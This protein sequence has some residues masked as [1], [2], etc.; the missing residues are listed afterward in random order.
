MLFK[1]WGAA[2]SIPGIWL[3]SAKAWCS[4]V[5][6]KQTAG[7]ELGKKPGR[8]LPGESL[9]S[10]RGCEGKEVQEVRPSSSAWPTWDLLHCWPPYTLL[11]WCVAACSVPG[12]GVEATGPLA[13]PGHCPRPTPLLLLCCGGSVHLLVRH[14]VAGINT[15][16]GSWSCLPSSW[17]CWSLLES[18]HARW[19]LPFF[20]IF[21]SVFTAEKDISVFFCANWKGQ[22]SMKN[23]M[24]QISFPHFII[25]PL[26]KFSLAPSF[27]SR[28]CSFIFWKI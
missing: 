16:L 5:G 4:P 18:S 22:K 15:M 10:L 7:R 12:D 13:A 3:K 27:C 6:L 26:L 24:S 11:A 2:Y 1:A 8:N 21:Q 20:F 9:P 28:I 14:G 25:S 23:S 19:N 17:S